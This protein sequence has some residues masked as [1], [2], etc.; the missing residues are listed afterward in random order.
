MCLF[1]KF[2]NIAF[3]SRTKIVC[4]PLQF[5]YKENASTIQCGSVIFEV[6]NYYINN[7]SCIFMCILDVSKAFDFVNHLSM[8][9]KL[10]LR[11]MCPT[12]FLMYTF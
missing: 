12:K 8:F 4:N 6:F 7:D 5:V 1:S 2:E 10:K 9:N 3:L 11:N